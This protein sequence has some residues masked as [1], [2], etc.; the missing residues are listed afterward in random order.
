MAGPQ[1][2]PARSTVLHCKLQLPLVTGWATRGR[3]VGSGHFPAVHHLSQ[4]RARTGCKDWVQGREEAWVRGWGGLQ[5]T[6]GEG[7]SACSQDP[8][9]HKTNSSIEF[10]LQLLHHR[11]PVG[12]LP[13]PCSVKSPHSPPPTCCPHARSPGTCLPHTHPP[14]SWSAFT[15]FHHYHNERLPCAPSPAAPP[16]LP[17]DRG[18]AHEAAAAADAD[19]E[20]DCL[21]RLACAHH[22]LAQQHHS[23]QRLPCAPS[24][25]APPPLPGA[26]TRSSNISPGVTLGDGA[27]V[28]GSIVGLRAVIGESPGRLV[29]RG[30]QAFGHLG[31]WNGDNW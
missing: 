6:P 18:C 21:S 12:R 30:V 16:P 11:S 5:L 4:Q 1:Q 23:S 2:A 3:T 7:E 15:T 8:V 28:R 29:C 25:A 13:P 10:S 27:V 20:K 24:P 19:A 17:A 31:Q 26:H 9:E 14:F 22:H